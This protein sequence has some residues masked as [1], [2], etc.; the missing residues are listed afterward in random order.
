M[1]RLSFARIKK[2]INLGQVSDIFIYLNT[3]CNL[4]CKYCNSYILDSFLKGKVLSFKVFKKSMDYILKNNKD[5]PITF[6]GGEPLIYKS[7]LIKCINYLILNGASN[8]NISVFTNATLLDEEFANFV[9]SKNINL[10]ISLDGTKEV[11]DMN[12]VFKTTVGSVYQTVINNI[13]KYDLKRQVVINMLITPSNVSKFYDNCLHLFLLGFKKL[14]WDIDC[15][16]DWSKKDIEKLNVSIKKFTV[17]FNNKKMFKYFQINNLYFKS[18]KKI[19]DMVNITLM[20]DGHLYL[21]DMASIYYYQ[22]SP[23]NIFK[24]YK[25]FLEDFKIIPT[26]N[27]FFCGFG[28]YILMKNKFKNHS[29]LLKVLIRYKKIRKIFENNIK[30]ISKILVQ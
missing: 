21:C 25:N 15:Q 19:N 1:I 7:L 2:L 17:Y 11:N 6:Y 28:F 4:K 12:R 3:S 18:N 14:N 13:E 8:H 5:I 24:S 22:R 30:S 23:D 9:R 10:I 29:D 16:S 27:E 26:P 20:N